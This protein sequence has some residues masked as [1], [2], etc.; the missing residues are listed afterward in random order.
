[1]FGGEYPGGALYS[2]SAWVAS[3]EKEVQGLTNAILIR[4]HGFIRISPEDI[5][6]NMPPETVGKS[7]EL[8]LAALKN[9][10]RFESVEREVGDAS[11]SR[12]VHRRSRRHV[13]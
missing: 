8:Y 2:A 12:D 6:A 5:M 1:V 10:I 3:H 13:G 9:A 4:W 7:K 11:R